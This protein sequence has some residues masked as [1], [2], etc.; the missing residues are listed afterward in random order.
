[1]GKTIGGLILIW[2]LVFT[3]ASAFLSACRIFGVL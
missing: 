2:L 3:V 1:M